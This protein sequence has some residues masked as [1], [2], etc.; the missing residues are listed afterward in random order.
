MAWNLKFGLASLAK[1]NLMSFFAYGEWPHV[2]STED[3]YQQKHA[4]FPVSF[5]LIWIFLE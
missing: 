5:G 2:H 3:S 1:R 4:K